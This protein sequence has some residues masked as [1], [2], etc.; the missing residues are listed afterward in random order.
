[1][2]SL[3]IVWTLSLFATWVLI[4]QVYFVCERYEEPRTT[5]QAYR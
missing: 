4:L 1:M 5:L 2:Y 3:Y